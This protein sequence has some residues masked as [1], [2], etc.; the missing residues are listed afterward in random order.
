[1][2]SNKWKIWRI[3]NSVVI[4]LSFFAPWVVMDWGGQRDLSHALIATGF[5]TLDY[6]G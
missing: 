6:Y 3:I 1:M 2:K 4:F 5:K